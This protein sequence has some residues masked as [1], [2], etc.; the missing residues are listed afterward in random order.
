MRL[1]SPE[2]A[3]WY[4]RSGEP[5]HTVM[6]LDNIERLTTVRDARKHNLL[7]S[8]TN[9]LGVIAKPELGAWKQEQAV[10]AALTLPR[11]EGET[12]DNFA[13]RVANDADSR[14][15][16]ATEFGTSLHA[17]AARLGISPLEID[18]NSPI[19]PWSMQYRDWL[20]MNVERV[21][22]T[23]RTLVDTGLGYAG[24]ADLLVQHKRLGLTLVDI[25]SQS[26]PQG[27]KPRRYN[28]WGYQLAAYRTAMG[29]HASCLNLVINSRAP[30]PVVEIEWSEDD[31][32][33]C[34][35]V[36]HSASL[37]WR[38]EKD[39]D[40]RAWTGKSA[41]VQETNVTRI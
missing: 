37:I 19:A 7:P 4:K 34:L 17:E 25:K 2:H 9:I 29:F 31:M 26:V 30:D 22:W 41:N 15:R 1:F 21:L 36:F 5:M 16:A 24:T 40:P 18:L 38:I 3:H 11:F 12:L 32:R 28:T 10:L 14:S 6:S 27:G 33:D 13:R 23:E 39:Y 8:V 20:T 35:A